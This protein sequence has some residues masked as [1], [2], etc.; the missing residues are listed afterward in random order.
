MIGKYYPLDGSGDGDGS[1]SGD[2]DGSGDGSGYG[3]GDG[4]GYGSG[5]G[6]GFGDGSGSG[7]GFGD[8]SGD[9]FGDGYGDGYGYGDGSGSYFAKIWGEWFET[10]G[11]I[12]NSLCLNIPEHHYD[13]ITKEFLYNVDNLESLRELREKIGLSKYIELFDAK[14]IDEDFDHQGNLMRLYKYDEK[15][16]IVK[17][18]EVI[19]PSTDR[20]YHL[21]PPDQKSTNCFAAKASTFGKTES[22]F[23]PEYET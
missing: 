20:M 12:E 18:L 23:K 14:I 5:D 7:Y 16:T 22:T 17:L 8:G 2:G 9:G 13:K 19:C 10:S 6:Y 15:G 1:G 11:K 4:S 21:Y 3:Y